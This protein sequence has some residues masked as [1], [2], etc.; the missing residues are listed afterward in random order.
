MKPF[1]ISAVAPVGSYV[2]P[3]WFCCWATK[4]V[5]EAALFSGVERSPEHFHMSGR[6]D[7]PQTGWERV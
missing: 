3:H 6:N 7:K 5:S 4:N 2:S 1:W